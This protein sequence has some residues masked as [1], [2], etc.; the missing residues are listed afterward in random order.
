MLQ[1][2]ALLGCLGIMLLPVALR[3]APRPP[4]EDAEPVSHVTIAVTDFPG[5]DRALGHFLSD[6]L[7][8]DL[9]HSDRLQT[10]EPNELQQ[11]LADLDMRD[12]GPM[13]PG[14]VRHL[15]D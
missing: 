2:C 4:T 10:L 14:Q 11:A 5:E 12:S 1:K 3:A 9:G 6:T 7:L 13:T 8:T 15:G